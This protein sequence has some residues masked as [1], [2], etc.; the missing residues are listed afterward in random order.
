MYI[1][2]DTMAQIN[3]RVDDG[4]K[5]DAEQQALINRLANE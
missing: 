3:V 1:R 4:L 5:R 2:G